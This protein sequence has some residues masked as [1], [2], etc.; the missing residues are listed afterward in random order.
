[1]TSYLAEKAKLPP[2]E[3][4]DLMKELNE[5]EENHALKELDSQKVSPL[6]D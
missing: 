6:K 2:G 1:M 5:L 4:D 3:E